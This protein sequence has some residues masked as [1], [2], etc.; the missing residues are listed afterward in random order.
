[1]KTECDVLIIGA[2][3]IGLTLA[4]ALAK[5][6]ERLRIIVIEKEDDI[7]LHASGRNSGVIHAGIYYPPNSLKGRFCVEGNANLKQYC[8]E[9]AIP[10]LEC[11]KLVVAMDEGEVLQ[12]EELYRRG[13]ANGARVKMVTKEEAAELEPAA[14]T[15]EAA[16]Y[17]P[18]TA[19]SEPR[20]VAKAL[21][22]DL[23]ALGVIILTGT[24]YE[25]WDGENVLTSKGTFTAQ[26]VVNAAGLY[27]DKIGRD[28][29]FSKRYTIIPFKGLYLK[30]GKNKSDIKIHIYP[31]PNLA[32]PFL[33]VHFTKTVDGTIKIGP[34][35]IPGFWRENYKGLENFK[36]EEAWEILKNE[37]RLFI[38]NSFNFRALALEEIRKYS[39][40][41]FIGLARRLA[42]GIDP[43]GF[44]DFT[45][46]GIRAQLVDT[47][48]ME[49]VQD[50]VIEGDDR[51]THILNAVSPGW[52]CSFPFSRYTAEKYLL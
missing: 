33:G 17:S 39:R 16:L 14:F 26:K 50:F 25:G 43:D 40:R 24:R 28:F 30:Y 35:A 31:V 36:G 18:D 8:R 34:T 51:S 46:P 49:L 48:K 1:M 32:F 37:T 5:Q 41:Y 23:T 11:G 19:S 6:R 38:S 9:Q 27:A 44:S 47:E 13:T 2:G 7:S 20:S 29:G 3:I 21:E 22:A 12:L 4:Y 15:H 42:P 52:T 45:T 10:L